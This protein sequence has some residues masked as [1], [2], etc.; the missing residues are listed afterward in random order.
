MQYKDDHT[1]IA[2]LLNFSI[3]AG[4]ASIVGINK[5]EMILHEA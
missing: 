3:R 2:D 1:S 5:K 4:A